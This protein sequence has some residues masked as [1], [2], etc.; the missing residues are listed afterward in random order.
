MI[1]YEI[2]FLIAVFA[3][4]YSIILTEPHMLLNPLYKKL[5]QFFNGATCKR[6]ARQSKHWLFKIIIHC[7]K[8]IAGQIS[9]WLYTFTHIMEY[10]EYPIETFFLHMAFITMTIFLVCLIKNIYTKYIQND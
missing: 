3:F 8:C 9:L 6:E 10:Q 2:S 1:E 7:E 4:V 5:D